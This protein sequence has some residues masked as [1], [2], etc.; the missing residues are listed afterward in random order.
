MLTALVAVLNLPTYYLLG[1][2]IC[3]SWHEAGAAIVAGPQV[4][5]RR[6][7]TIEHLAELRDE[8]Y[9]P[10]DYWLAAK[11]VWF[12]FSSAVLVAVQVKIAG[13]VL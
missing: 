1:R 6:H 12:L 13:W 11:L 4:L 7:P 10:P 2:L 3:G 8:G 5:S 9:E